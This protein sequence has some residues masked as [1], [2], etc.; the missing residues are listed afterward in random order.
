[1]LQKVCLTFE[2]PTA[3]IAKAITIVDGGILQTMFDSVEMLG[4]LNSCMFPMAFI[5]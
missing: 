3:F 4:N 1:M 5:P 2:K